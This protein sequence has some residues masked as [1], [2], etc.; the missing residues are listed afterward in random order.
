MPNKAPNPFLFV[1]L[2]LASFGA[3]YFLARHRAATYPA[4]QQPRQQDNPL[5]P[6]RHHTKS[7]GDEASN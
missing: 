4:S 5:V 6:P 7:D 2:S 3:F 1:G